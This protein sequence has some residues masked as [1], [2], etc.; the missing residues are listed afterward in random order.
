[1]VLNFHLRKGLAMMLMSPG[2]FATSSLFLFCK[3]KIGQPDSRLTTIL[4][5]L[6]FLAPGGTFHPA[7]RK[8]NSQKYCSFDDCDL[9]YCN[10]PIRNLDN[11]L[12]I[13]EI[14]IINYNR[15]AKFSKFH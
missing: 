5:I 12:L 1:M 4:V 7:W 14:L 2:H 8:N 3:I 13:S 11:L 10:F 6:A 9:L 15:S